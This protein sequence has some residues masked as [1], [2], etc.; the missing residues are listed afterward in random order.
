VIQPACRFGL[1]QEIFV[2]E[3]HEFSPASDGFRCR[4]ILS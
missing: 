1:Q 3:I 4:S 2:D